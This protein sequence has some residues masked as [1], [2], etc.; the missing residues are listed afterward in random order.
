MTDL[1]NMIGLIKH[2]GF[3]TFISYLGKQRLATIIPVPTLEF[4]HSMISK[5]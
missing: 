5:K 2:F 4:K 1:G 3:G